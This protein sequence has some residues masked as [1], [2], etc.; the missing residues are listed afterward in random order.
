MKYQS[1]VSFQEAVSGLFSAP[2]EADGGR[3]S[4]TWIRHLLTSL[5]QRALLQPVDDGIHSRNRRTVTAGAAMYCDLMF[6]A[7]EQFSQ[8]LQPALKQEPATE[9]AVG[10][11]V[12][13]HS[14]PPCQF[15]Q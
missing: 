9:K 12:K 7:G 11:Q 14:I 1:F 15:L 10:T 8:A 13:F 4:R 3:R 5:A 2:L 6:P